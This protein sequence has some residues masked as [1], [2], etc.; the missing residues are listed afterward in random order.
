MCN[1]ID[2]GELSLYDTVSHG[3]VL[4]ALKAIAAVDADHYPENLGITL[5]CN[6]PWSFTSA[7]SVVRLFLDTK[8]QAKF[9][10]LGKGKEQ[11]KALEEALGGI[12]KVPAF[13]GGEC[14]C[15]GGCVCLDPKHEPTERVLT[16]AQV[17]YARFC[18]ANRESRVPGDDVPGD[19][20]EGLG[21]LD[22]NG[23]A[24]DVATEKDEAPEP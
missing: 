18:F 16:D 24:G 17:R 21:A 11:L 19:V 14:V 20:A 12:E 3:E 10:V 8:T 5:V 22:L 2:V 4:R 15:P 7:W 23:D 13:L 1:V 9:K 6:A